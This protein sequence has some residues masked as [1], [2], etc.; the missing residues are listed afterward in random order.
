LWR[1][2]ELHRIKKDALERLRAESPEDASQIEVLSVDVLRSR[3][4]ELYRED[5]RLARALLKYERLCRQ[6]QMDITRPHPNWDV[7]TVEELEKEIAQFLRSGIAAA[8]EELGVEVSDD[9]TI[10]SEK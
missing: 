2:V 10:A 9:G 1:R 4:L 8:R 5:S 6:A 7:V 3:V